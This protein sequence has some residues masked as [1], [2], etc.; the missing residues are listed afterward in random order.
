MPLTNSLQ[1]AVRRVRMALGMGQLDKTLHEVVRPND[2][3][4]RADN[5]RSD[6]FTLYRRPG[7]VKVYSFRRLPSGETPPQQG[8]G[9]ISFGTDGNAIRF[10]GMDTGVGGFVLRLSFTRTAA[11]AGETSWVMSAKFPGGFPPAIEI[12]IDDAFSLTVNWLYGGG[13]QASH[14]LG[15]IPASKPVYN[16]MLVYDSQAGE[17]RVYESGELQDTLSI[18]TGFALF[19]DTED[20]YLGYLDDG[21]GT[22]VADSEF[23]G[24]V[25]GWCF[26]TLAGTELQAAGSPNL[27]ETLQKYAFQEWPNPASNMVLH[28]LD[29]NEH[30]A[31]STLSVGTVI[32]D[33][34]RHKQD[35]TVTGDVT[36]TTSLLYTCSPGNFIGS[37]QEADGGVINVIAYGGVP[38]IDQVLKGV[39]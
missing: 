26:M 34:S 18:G 21:F 20:W 13:L 16:L 28:C 12:T 9:A 32:R 1:D 15:V 6:D 10:P 3:L 24:S 25:D 39:P 7:K 17:S 31:S 2:A 23:Q 22:K 30:A 8:S 35:A 38:V 36:T 4:R 5:V 33:R 29:F 19:R 27:M 37:L 14:V 11:P